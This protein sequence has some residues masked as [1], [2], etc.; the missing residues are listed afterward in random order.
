MNKKLNLVGLVLFIVILGFDPGR[1]LAQSYPSKPIRFIV[2]AGAGG[3]NDIVA[4]L[5][6]AKLADCCKQAVLV[7]VE[8]RGGGGGSIGAGVAANAAPDGYTMLFISVSQAINASLYRDLPYDIVKDLAPITQLSAIPII[9]VVNPSLPVK[10]VKELIVLAKSQPG[11]LTY[12][13]AGNGSSTHVAMELLKNMAGID[14]VHIPYKGQAPSFIDLLAGRVDL[15]FAGIVQALPYVKEGR[16][17]GLAVGSSKRSP[18][19]PDLPTV[20]EAGVPGFEATSWHGILVPARTPKEIIRWLNTEIVKILH[21]PD[22]QERL[23]DKGAQL[24]GSTPEEFA[25]FLEAEIAKWSKVVK[26]NRIRID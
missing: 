11:R 7:V 3:S 13:S 6:G 20:A 18:T 4:P 17:R 26:D 19:A 5:I 22:V 25:A 23:S 15:T 21:L 8:N 24:I 10:S 14:M 2:P 1:A 9:L 12:A 16:L